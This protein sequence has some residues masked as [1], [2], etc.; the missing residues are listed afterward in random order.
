MKDEFIPLTWFSVVAIFASGFMLSDA[1]DSIQA[2]TDPAAAFFL[3]F[4]FA[5]MARSDAKIRIQNGSYTRGW[6]MWRRQGPSNLDAD[7][8]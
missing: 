3:S 2:H 5:V 8:M 7:P 6:F 1:I 4:M